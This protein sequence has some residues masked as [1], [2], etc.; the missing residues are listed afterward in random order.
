MPGTEGASLRRCCRDAS[1]RW[2]L[3]ARASLGFL[4]WKVSKGVPGSPS[5]CRGPPEAGGSRREDAGKQGCC[6]QLEGLHAHPTVCTDLNAAVEKLD[7]SGFH[8]MRWLGRNRQGHLDLP[9]V[10]DWGNFMGGNFGLKGS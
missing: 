6:W 10:C 1:P 8:E 2:C 4:E 3:R 7:K 9:V 5:L